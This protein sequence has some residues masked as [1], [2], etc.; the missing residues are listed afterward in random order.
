MSSITLN[1]NVENAPNP[2]R[3]HFEKT[4]SGGMELS[5]IASEKE[6]NPDPRISTLLHQL[7]QVENITC[8]CLARYIVFFFEA[9]I[10]YI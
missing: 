5:N 8:V 3:K 10:S 9:V 6:K 7:E 1:L 2:T 4:N